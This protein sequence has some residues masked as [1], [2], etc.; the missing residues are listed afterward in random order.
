MS[1]W[2]WNFGDFEIYH[3]SLVHARRVGYGRPIACMWK[4]YR[5]E[6]NVVFEKEVDTEGGRFTVYGQ[7]LGEVVVYSNRD[8]YSPANRK[9]AFGEEITLPAGSFRIQA[10]IMNLD[11]FPAILAVGCVETDGSWFCDDRSGNRTP[12]GTWDVFGDPEKR[13]EV[14]PFAYRPVDPVSREA[15]EGGVLYDF[16]R[17]LSCGLTVSG[18]TGPAALRLG[19]SREEAMD[20]EWCVIRHT[21][22][23]ERNTVIPSGF[24]YVF[25]SDPTAE[26]CAEFEYLPITNRGRFSSGEE[27][28]QWTWDTAAYTF[29]LNCREFFF[30]GIKRD[31][32]VW[33]ADAYQTQFVNHYS[34]MDPEIEKRT[35]IALGGKRPFTQHVN[36]IVDYTFFWIMGIWEYYRTWGDADFVKQ[37]LPQL[38]EVVS[39]IEAR[40]DEDGFIRGKNADWVFIDWAWDIDKTG[41]VSGEQ[42]LLAEAL[43]DFGKM[44]GICGEDGGKY[45]REA[46][47]LRE[48]IEER[49][50]DSEKG[51]FIDSFESGKRNVSRHCNLWAY[52]FLPLSE[53]RKKSIYE[54]VVLN[55]AV[56]AITT[57][58]F[59]FY[60]NQV[61]CE[62]GDPLRKLEDSIRNYYGPM[63]DLGATALFEQFDPS[64]KGAEH[65]AMYNLPYDKSLCHAWSSSPIYLLGAY[66]LGVRNT[67]IAY[68]TFEVR[69]DPGDLGTFSGIVPLPAGEVEV[70][71]GEDRISVTASAS[72]G[73]LV[74]GGERIPLPAGETVAVKR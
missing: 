51:C 13:P 1:Q 9:Y 17:E 54:N 23:P 12:V 39:F 32:W 20:P 30:D 42:I 68:D 34:F 53:E 45:G 73:T 47:L 63:K 40:R 3:S 24:R 14:F 55:D 28:V 69:P 27:I 35:L 38:K 50:W 25:L 52:L 65:Y 11:T 71:V 72:G 22:T 6:P 37:M 62:A 33:S 8:R 56:P 49:F 29:F 48:R 21:L 66:R 57:P 18:L 31:R 10:Q 74:Y 61:H 64:Q 2:I 7:G 4:L 16:G 36:T 41:A 70:S 5:P 67:G 59:K 58:Y 44:L 43:D 19:E 15:A 46:A 60:E 26:L